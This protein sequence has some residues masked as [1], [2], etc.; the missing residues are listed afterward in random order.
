MFLS[1][2]EQSKMKLANSFIV[3]L[4]LVIGNYSF[5][6]T[7]HLQESNDKKLHA[8]HHEE[9]KGEKMKRHKLSIYMGYTF[10]PQAIPSHES[11]LVPTFGLDYTYRL[12]EK[13]SIGV[14]ND[15]EIAQYMVE[16]PGDGN[17]NEHG[18]KETLEREYAYVGALVLYYSPWEGWNIG[19]GPGLEVE[20][21]RNLFVG[22]FIIEK[23]F[24]LHDGWELSPNFQYDIKGNIYDTW[25]FGVSIGKRF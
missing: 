9:E 23:E 11:L 24:E 21:N 19:A 13:F 7:N 17:G 14:L 20:K 10:I 22:K 8:T 25:S 2:N 18:S 6:Q 15:I 3:L 1:L 16:I 5:A 12:S 4:L